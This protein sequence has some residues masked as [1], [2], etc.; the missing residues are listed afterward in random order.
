MGRHAAA[1]DA[2]TDPIVA[3]A[4]ASRA[5]APTTRHAPDAVSATAQGTE[6]DL[7]WPGDTTTGGGLGWPGS[8]DQGT[9]GDGLVEQASDQAAADQ[10][11]VDQGPV[12]QGLA[13]GEADATARMTA[14]PAVPGTVSDGE[15]E[16]PGPRGWRRLFGGHAA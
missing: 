9:A 7:G 5:A 10:G 14:V 11:P 2:G 12:D 16:P 6:G 15:P 3:A 4:L 8:T 1:E 13:A